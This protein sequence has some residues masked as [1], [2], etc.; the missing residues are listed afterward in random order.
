MGEQLMKAMPRIT[1]EQPE[2]IPKIQRFATAPLEELF[3]EMI[4]AG[5]P[6]RQ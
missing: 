2:L 3:S 1:A 4:E 6:N 5:Y